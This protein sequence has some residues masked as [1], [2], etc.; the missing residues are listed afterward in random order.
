M[1]RSSFKFMPF[2][3]SQPDNTTDFVQSGVLFGLGLGFIGMVGTLALSQ[4]LIPAEPG[5]PAPIYSYEKVGKRDLSTYIKKK[6]Q[7]GEKLPSWLQAWGSQFDLKVLSLEYVDHSSHYV[8]SPEEQHYQNQIRTL[9]QQLQ[10]G[11]ALRPGRANNFA[12]WITDAHLETNVPI[13]F[14]AAVIATE[15]SFRYQ[16]VSSVGAIGPAQV[17]PLHWQDYC[18]LDLTDP[19]QNVLC[20][21]KALNNYYQ[22]SCQG[23]WACV[24]ANYNVGPRNRANNVFPG[25]EERYLGRINEKL[26]MAPALKPAGVNF[27]L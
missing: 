26:S 22:G 1:H 2:S 3:H 6:E 19:G 4:S 9:S 8:Y 5:S 25:A 27:S 7:D 17:R 20:G 16:V 21:A 10:A 12:R 14:I 13:G 18:N 11:Y 15:S 23:D 24:F